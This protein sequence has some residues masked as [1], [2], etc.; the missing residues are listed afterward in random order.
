ML[1][2]PRVSAEKEE[3]ICGGVRGSVC[4]LK[5]TRAWHAILSMYIRPE[6]DGMSGVPTGIS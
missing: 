3:W 1:G 6:K 4:G 2:N 5:A